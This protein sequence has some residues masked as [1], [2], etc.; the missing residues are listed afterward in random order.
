MEDV[1]GGHSADE[2]FAHYLADWE[3]ILA[4][5]VD[6]AVVT[7]SAIEGVRGL[8]LAGGLGRGAPWPLS[9]ID[10]LPIYADR[11]G[12]PARREVER[13]RVALLEPWI[14]E[15][16]WTGL[17][18]GRLAFAEDE[19]TRVLNAP[20][21]AFSALLHDERWYHALDKGYRGRARYDP[22]GLAGSLA[23]WFTAHRF[24]PEVVA[25]RLMR[26]RREITSAQRQLHD[27]LMHGDLLGGAVQIESA[28][29]W[30]RIWLLEGWGERDNSL[31]RIGTRFA[32]LARRHGRRDLVDELEALC[33]LDEAS[34]WRRLAEAPDWVHERHDRSYRARRHV[35]EEVSRLQDARDTLRVCTVYAMRRPLSQPYPSWLAIPAN[36]ELLEEKAERLKTLIRRES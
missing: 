22:D 9:D 30:L 10:L 35:G 19:V 17:D 31:G 28:V 27:C 24:H 25:F 23:A 5:R 18:I 12:E 2:R 16:W 4:R 1:I 32:E 6:E 11:S 26:E 34:V 14:A 21:P 33:D 15:G 13:R 20:E 8:I 7:F 29:K 3:A 36:A